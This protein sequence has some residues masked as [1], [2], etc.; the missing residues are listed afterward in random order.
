MHSVVGQHACSAHRRCP[1]TTEPTTLRHIEIVDPNNGG[2]VVTA[3]ELLCPANKLGE[4]GRRAYRQKQR[5]YLEGGVNLVEIDLIREG[6]FTVAVPERL[7]PADFRTPYTVCVRRANRP[8][9]VEITR[10]P[11]R[12]PLP[13]VRVPLRPTDSDIVLSLQPL[14]AE[15]YQR[16]R[17][18]SIDYSQ[19]PSPRLSE[20]DQQWAD[21]L[22]RTRRS[23]K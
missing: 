23:D 15:C 21:Q 6:G 12:Q 9:E 3:I 4:E 22:L 1:T 11:L 20:E 16:G 7:V 8:S 2:R 19:P 10:V 17:Y 5:E 14:L 13:N 18:A